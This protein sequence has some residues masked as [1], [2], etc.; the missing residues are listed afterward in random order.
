MSSRSP[1]TRTISPEDEDYDVM[2]D[3]REHMQ[4]VLKKRARLAPVRL[5]VQGHPSE[6]L[7]DYL[8]QRL[9]PA[10]GAC[11]SSPKHPL[12][13]GYVYALEGKL[14]PESA[15]AL[16][17]TKYTPQWPAVSTAVRR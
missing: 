9:D 17:Y 6:E 14:P 3:F 10:A 2:E 16:C 12:A 1:A 11:V 4:K 5:E 15:A 8:C 13:M 7:L